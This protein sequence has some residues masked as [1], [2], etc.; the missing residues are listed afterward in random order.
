MR[1]Y[2]LIRGSA[3]VRMSS[4]I[5]GHRSYR[6]GPR[7]YFRLDEPYGAV[8]AAGKH[9]NLVE[10]VVG[11]PLHGGFAMQPLQRLTTVQDDL[12]RGDAPNLGCHCVG[13]LAGAP[14]GVLRKPLNQRQGYRCW[15]S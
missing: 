14:G 2:R 11:G 10:G 5:A 13:R 3:T 8:G 6:P 1:L 4:G 12:D 7:C 9:E 15:T